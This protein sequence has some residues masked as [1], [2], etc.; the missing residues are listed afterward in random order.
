MTFEEVLNT[1]KIG[2]KR[3]MQPHG[4]DEAKIVVVTSHPTFDCLKEDGVC[5]GKKTNNG[6][7]KHY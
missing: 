7:E 6:N 1:E 5:L 2:E 4:N 3:F